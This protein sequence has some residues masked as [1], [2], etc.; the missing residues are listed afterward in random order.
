[1]CKRF[2]VTILKILIDHNTEKLKIV[3]D[4][5][6][7]NDDLEIDYLLLPATVIQHRPAVIDWLSIASVNPSDIK[8]QYHSPKIW[9]TS[10]I[11]CTC[12]L[13][14]SLVYTPHNGHIYITTGIM[15]LNGNSPLELRD[16]G[17]T[18]YKKY[19]EQK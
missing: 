17:V 9:T 12:I 16:G 11:V 5:L 15:E 18:T 8:C 19:F 14:E 10:G 4:K 7:L 1:M 3:L 2:Q 13:K 6:C